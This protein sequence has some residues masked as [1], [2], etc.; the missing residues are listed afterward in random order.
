MVETDY[1]HLTFHMRKNFWL[2]YTHPLKYMA[3]FRV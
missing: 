3:I 2:A 1:F